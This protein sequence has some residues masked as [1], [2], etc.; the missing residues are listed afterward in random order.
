MANKTALIGTNRVNGSGDPAVENWVTGDTMTTPDGDVVITDATV[1]N[2]SDATPQQVGTGAGSPGTSA[3]YSRADH[4]HQTNTQPSSAT[5]QP[6]GVT[7]AAGSSTDYSRADHV[8]AGA[9]AGTAM[10]SKF[11]ATAA[12]A[13]YTIPGYPANTNALFVFVNNILVPNDQYTEDSST[14]I[15]FT[16]YPGLPFVGGEEIIVFVPKGADGLTNQL[17]E[18]YAASPGQ[19][20]FNLTGSY[21]VGT[22]SLLVLVN[23]VLKTVG[24]AADYQETGAQQVTF[25]AGLTGGEEVKFLVPRGSTTENGGLYSPGSGADWVDPDP[26]TVGEALDRIAAALATHLGPIP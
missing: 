19:T 14:Q 26:T 24:V 18:V 1:P 20:I 9:S 25:N 8:H 3:D 7:G 17:Y 6:V 16:T 5:P 10:Y 2:P 4:V 22:N 13:T 15:T 11:A 23:G 12:V 21:D